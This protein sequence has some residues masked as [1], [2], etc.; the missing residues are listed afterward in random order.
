MM[1]RLEAAEMLNTSTAVALG[2]GSL[3]KGD[4]SRARSR[5][6]REANK[7]MSRRAA[8]ASPEVFR[9]MGIG[10]EVVPVEEND[11]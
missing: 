10:V 3:K 11:D 5:L 6:M 8:K 1:P 2:T 9:M 4:A 7:G